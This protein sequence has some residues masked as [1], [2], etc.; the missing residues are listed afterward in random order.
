MNY[1]Q[2]PFKVPSDDT[3]SSIIEKTYR[4]FGGEEHIQTAEETIC[5]NANLL[6]ERNRELEEELCM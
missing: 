1:I 4:E 5:N 3:L 6:R 2:Q